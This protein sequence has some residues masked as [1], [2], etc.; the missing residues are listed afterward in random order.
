M[1]SSL[2]ADQKALFQSESWGVEMTITP[3]SGSVLNVTDA[4]LVMGTL[5]VDRYVSTGSELPIGTATAG[6]LSFTLDNANHDF[7]GVVFAGASIYLRFYVVD[8]AD[9]SYVYLPV[10]YFT[11]DEAPRILESI[12]IVALDA[13]VQFD[14][15]PELTVAFPC[16]VEALVNDLATIAGVTLGTTLTAL[17]NYNYTIPSAPEQ[18]QDLTARQLLQYC[19]QIMGVNAQIGRNGSLYL[20]EYSNTSSDSFDE[21]QRY[22]SDIR[23]DI[24][25]TGVQIASTTGD[26]A[27]TGNEGYVLEIKD[28]PLIQTDPTG[29]LSGL[30]YLCDPDDP[31]VFAPFSAVV[32]PV[33]WYDPMDVVTFTKDGVGHI[34]FCTKVLQSINGNTA[35]E[36]TGLSETI[37]GFATIDP[38]TVREQQI[39]RDIRTR[40]S[41]AVSAAEQN[42]ISFSNIIANSLGLYDLSVENLDGSTTFYFGDA[43]TLEDSSVIYTF[44]ANGFAWTS[45]WNGG[46]PTWENGIDANGN[47]ILRLLTLY[48]LTAD[49]IEASSITA[50]ELNLT[51]NDTIFGDQTVTEVINNNGVVTQTQGKANANEAE[52]NRQAKYIKIGDLSSVQNADLYGLGKYGVAVGRVDDN[53]NFIA[54]SS[55]T[56]NKLS[57]YDEY[58]TD[59]AYIS[60][61][62]LH[63]RN[64]EIIESMK[65]GHRF[66]LLINTDSTD[67]DQITGWGSLTLRW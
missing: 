36:G 5:T 37:K 33:P 51:L 50:N 48:K 26:V 38:L 13:M 27:M 42:A 4:N 24:T 53:N 12:S 46:S 56:Q 60:S 16:T 65:L 30:F 19:C 39:L 20:L 21:T 45:D 22:S 32:I 61:A 58:G 17:P 15:I 55:F 66:T 43:E 34:V 64:A 9:N 35:L 6:Q 67:T 28:N 63:I 44:R 25:V 18:L 47:A 49:Q 7:D 57:F 10:G 62:A 59:V 2:S 52:I 54:Y 29:L 11:V 1:Y 41:E 40:A 3:T 8:P 14:V 31:I 23:E